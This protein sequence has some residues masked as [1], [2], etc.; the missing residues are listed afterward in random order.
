MSNMKSLSIALVVLIF[1]TTNAFAQTEII[2]TTMSKREQV[3][4]LNAFEKYS[5]RASISFLNNDMKLASE[6]IRKALE[7]INK[8][9]L[10][11]VFEGKKLL[12]ESKEGLEGLAQNLEAGVNIS[13]GE[14]KEIFISA[15]NAIIIN[16][17]YTTIERLHKQVSN[18]ADIINQFN[19][20]N[21]SAEVG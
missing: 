6:E 2:S 16:H 5:A 14:F 8:D 7:V 10:Y 12:N 20:T 1:M 17:H 9:A 18:P 13:E 4:L 15:H 11:A 3:T 21:S 19:V